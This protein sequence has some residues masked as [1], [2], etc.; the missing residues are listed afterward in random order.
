[1]MALKPCPVRSLFSEIIGKNGE[2]STWH[3]ACII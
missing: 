3:S 1:M 2:V